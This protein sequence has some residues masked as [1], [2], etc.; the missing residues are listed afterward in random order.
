MRTWE[1]LPPGVL[2][3]TAAGEIIH[4]ASEDR[5]PQAMALLEG[6]S[7]HGRKLARAAARLPGETSE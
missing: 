4:G 2:K 7:A 5:K 3:A 6:L 1:S